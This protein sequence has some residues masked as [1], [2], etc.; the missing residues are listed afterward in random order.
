MPV[1]QGGVNMDFSKNKKLKLT[2]REIM[3]EIEPLRLK[4]ARMGWSG[5]ALIILSV[6]ALIVVG[7]KEILIAD[8]VALTIVPLLVFLA[9][10]I[11]LAV[12]S[13]RL[14]KKVSV[15]VK[16]N[17]IC[18]LLDEAFEVETYEHN[19]FL[20]ADAVAQPRFIDG[21]RYCVGSDYL[22][23]KYKGL[24]FQFSDVRLYYTYTS[25]DSDGHS[26][27][28][29]RDVFLGQ[30]F[31]FD[32]DGE[33]PLNPA[34]DEIKWLN[35]RK[36]PIFY[37]GQANGQTHVAMYSSNNFFEVNSLSETKNLDSLRE[38]FQAEI[39][40]MHELMDLFV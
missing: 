21:W 17:L 32:Y 30:W 28:H 8:N 37:I 40:K 10:G 25:S 27:T 2:D 14:S 15:F 4:S 29:E 23:G 22:K 39:K 3:S 1:G 11:M 5:F 13:F 6:T 24:K 20:K 16:E 7:T 12:L 26:T 38:K 31:I 19:S 34:T 35:R 36:K 33:L 18:H 9:L